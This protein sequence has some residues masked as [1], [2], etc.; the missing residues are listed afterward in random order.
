[1]PLQHQALDRVQHQI[2][3][4]FLVVCLAD[5]DLLSA[6]PLGKEFLIHPIHVVANHRLGRIQN[7]LGRTVI[8]LQ[9]DHLCLRVLLPE[10]IDVAE[11][12]PAPFVDRLV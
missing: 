2:C 1:M 5:R 3:F 11:I 9:Q 4:F 8:L 7:N 12:S 6:V 10:T